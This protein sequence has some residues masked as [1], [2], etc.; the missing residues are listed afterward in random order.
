MTASVPIEG[1]P[2]DTLSFDQRG[3]QNRQTRVTRLLPP[4]LVISAVS[5][6][7]GLL[8]YLHMRQH[9]TRQGRILAEI[10]TSVDETNKSFAEYIR[11]RGVVT[12][13]RRLHEQEFHSEIYS[14]VNL[15]EDKC[16]RLETLSREQ[17]DALAVARKQLEEANA[18]GHELEKCVFGLL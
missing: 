4:L 14:K 5:V 16:H 15:L 17:G 1:A 3:S 11:S 6:A 7:L 10:R 9:I 12:A 18:R 2:T 8:P 13:A